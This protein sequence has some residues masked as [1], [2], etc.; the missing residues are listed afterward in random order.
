M[1]IVTIQMIVENKSNKQILVH[2]ESSRFPKIC[3]QNNG[4]HGPLITDSIRGEILCGSCGMI[5]IDKVE[6]SG[7]EQQSFTLEQYN[8]RSRTGIGSAL[9]IDDKGLSTVIGSQDKDASG[10][11]ISPYMKYAFNRLRTWDSRSKTDS[12]ERSLRSAFV[13]LN[14]LK[15]KL[16]L[17]DAIVERAAYLYRKAL[18]KKITQGRTIAG[19]ILASLYA[20]CRETNAPRTLQDIASAGNITV[21]D[22]SRHYRTLFNT[23]GLQLESYDSTDFVTRISSTVGL[24]E[25]TKRGALDILLQAKEKG[26]TDGKNPISLAAAALYLS[27]VIHEESAT[28]KKIADASGISSVTIRNVGKLIRKSLG[29]KNQ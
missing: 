20:A 7:P 26:I 27:S 1:C 3:T 21:K 13:I 17:S 12:T 19:I 10:N 29:M 6:D 11:S 15:S 16:D 22:L 4:I 18:T 2:E 23:L 25:K 24:S 28:Q 9:S 5:L 14:T 8:E